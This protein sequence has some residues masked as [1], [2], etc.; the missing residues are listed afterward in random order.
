[1]ARDALGEPAAGEPEGNAFCYELCAHVV[2]EALRSSGLSRK[3]LPEAALLLGF[4][5]YPGRLGVLHRVADR[6]GI[7][8]IR[9]GVDTACS[10]GGHAVGSAFRLIQ[11]GATRIAVAAAVNMLTLKDVAGLFKLGI[12]SRAVIRPFDRR[13]TGTQVG[14][15]AAA[16][17]LEELGH[18]QARGAPVC[19]ELLAF[20]E[21]ADA[22]DIVPP[23][24]EG[25]GLSIAIERALDEAQV[26]AERLD[27]INAHGT[28]TR[29]NDPSET[30]AMKRAL[31]P[32]ADR[33]PISSTK[34][35]T[36]HTL[37]A[38]GMIE[39]VATVLAVQH[40]FVPPTLNLEV[41][42]PECDLDYTPL[43]ARHRPV[44]LAMSNSA[45][46]GG[47]Y[48]ALVFRECRPRH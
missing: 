27:Y 5:Q 6:F 43:V 4:V 30:R 19:A 2:E 1:V 20:G 18:A 39:A 32:A 35:I 33:I 37:A 48:S 28:G 44:R 26:D 29:L 12:L 11:N 22:H 13:R 15:G 40:S 7:G 34:P 46:F 41:A 24:L 36:G 42:D 16:L 31:G 23:H 8:G 14:E 3:R 10:A 45:G 38:A 25:L 9:C 17:V 47:L 21:G